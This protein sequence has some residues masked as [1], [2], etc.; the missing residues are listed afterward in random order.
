MTIEEKVEQELALKLF[1]ILS[2]ASRSVMDKVQDDIRNYGLNTTEF[3]VLELIY[4]K[5]D[6]P[7]QQIGK[8]VLLSSGSITY[9]VDK[10]EKKDLLERKPCPKD[11]RI[12]YAKITDKGKELMDSIF[13]KHREAIR[14]IFAGVTNDEKEQLIELLK[15]IGLYADNL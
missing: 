14:T 15:K 11:R 3:A 9:V 4:H 5:G 13:P 8:K 6:Q 10:L 7:I 12:T 1:I 2:R